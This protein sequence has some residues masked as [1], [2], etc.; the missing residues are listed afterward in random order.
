MPRS[1]T[2]DE[3]GANEFW[4]FS[5]YDPELFCGR[6]RSSSPTV[7][8]PERLISSLVIRTIGDGPS[9]STVGI[10]EPVTTT[11]LNSPSSSWA[12]AGMVASGIPKLMRAAVFTA[13]LILLVFAL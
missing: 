4:N 11:G 2:P 12:T 3:P 13:V 1:D 7:S 9:N 6:R 5:S 8:A 10:L